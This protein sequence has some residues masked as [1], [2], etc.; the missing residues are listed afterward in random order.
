MTVKSMKGTSKD[1]SLVPFMWGKGMGTQNNLQ[2][3][4]TEA[5]REAVRVVQKTNPALFSHST[6][7]ASCALAHDP[8]HAA[9][10]FDVVFIRPIVVEWER[11][12]GKGH[13]RAITARA[14]TIQVVQGI[15]YALSLCPTPSSEG[16][17]KGANGEGEGG[18]GG[19]VAGPA[20]PAAP[21][22]PAGTAA[23]A[24]TAATVG[25]ESVKRGGRDPSEVANIGSSTSLLKGAKGSFAPV[26]SLLAPDFQEE[27]L[28]F[29]GPSATYGEAVHVSH[30]M[31]AA[32]GRVHSRVKGVFC[33]PP[34]T[35]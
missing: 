10:N 19:G 23:T 32:M 33:P 24:A 31:R 12:I 9:H 22:A 15:V 17:E 28:G 11:A 8:E 35:H 20:A 2:R 6:L 18:D 25:G 5:T 34:P 3:I 26:W 4:T 27:V 7:L 13:S 14:F 16:G 30:F 21:A 29:V 1:D